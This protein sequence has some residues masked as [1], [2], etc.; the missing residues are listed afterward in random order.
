MTWIRLIILGT[1]AALSS[2]T[3][4]ATDPPL[5]DAAASIPAVC[6]TATKYYAQRNRRIPGTLICRVRVA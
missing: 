6:K 1:V 4:F 5:G 3:A 2:V